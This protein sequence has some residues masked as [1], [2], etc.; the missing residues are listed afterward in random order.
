MVKKNQLFFILNNLHAVLNLF[1]LMTNVYGLAKNISSILLLLLTIDRANYNRAF[2]ISS[3]LNGSEVPTF[4]P[5]Q[6]QTFCCQVAIK[7]TYSPM[8]PR[9]LNFFR[10]LFIAFS[11]LFWFIVFRLILFYI[12]VQFLKCKLIFSHHVLFIT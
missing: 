12:F 3:H 10:F 8:Q 11:R 9:E 5:P 2:L 7:S 6:G 1:R 4:S